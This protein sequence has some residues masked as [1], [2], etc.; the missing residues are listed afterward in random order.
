MGNPVVST[1]AQSC[2]RR[3]LTGTVA[4]RGSFRLEP[5]R[6][7]IDRERAAPRFVN[8]AVS[9]RAARPISVALC[10]PVASGRSPSPQR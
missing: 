10:R 1:V 6:A 4:G 8:Q 5:P 3:P 9:L 2:V 7:P